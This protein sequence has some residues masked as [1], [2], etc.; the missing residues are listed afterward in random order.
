MISVWKNRRAR[1]ESICDLDEYEI[2]NLP[3]R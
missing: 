3:A 1:R 2:E